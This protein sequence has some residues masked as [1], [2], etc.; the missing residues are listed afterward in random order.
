MAIAT[1]CSQGH[2]QSGSLGPRYEAEAWLESNPNPNAFAGNRFTSTEE[3]LAFVE[4]LYEHGAREV[5]VTGIR[6]EDWR[7]E[8]EGGPYADVLIIRL[9]SEPM[10]R[11]LLFQI[12]NEEMTREGFSP[13]ADIGQEELLLWWD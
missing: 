2:Q 3:A 7:I 12:A 1:S 10:Q 11:D 5:L 6:D 13:E 8:L 4:T 9:P